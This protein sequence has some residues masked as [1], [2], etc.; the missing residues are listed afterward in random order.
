MLLIQHYESEIRSVFGFYAD[1]YAQ[2]VFHDRQLCEHVNRTLVAVG[3]DGV[4]TGRDQP[5]SG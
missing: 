2:R 5:S 4:M 3:F 1:N